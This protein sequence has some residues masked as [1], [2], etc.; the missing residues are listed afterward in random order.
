MDGVEFLAAL[1]EI[2]GA[3]NA[4][5]YAAKFGDLDDI[6]MN[7]I[8]NKEALAFFAYTTGLEW[9][10]VINSQLWSGTAS[11]AVKKFSEVLIA[12]CRTFHVTQRMKGS[13]IEVFKLPT[14][15]PFVRSTTP[16]LS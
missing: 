12:D 10:Q 11:V 16:A 13:F 2:V 14:S 3:D 4:A 6:F 8:T 5:K 1:A 7:E 15:L 9:Y